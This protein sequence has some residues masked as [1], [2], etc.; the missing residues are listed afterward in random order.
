MWQTQGLRAKYGPC[1][2]ANHNYVLNEQ[3]LVIVLC[4][5]FSVFQV[6][7]VKLGL[8]WPITRSTRVQCEADRTLHKHKMMNNQLLT[9]RFCCDEM[10]QEEVN[11]SQ[12]RDSENTDHDP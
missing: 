12:N 5:F 11:H 6:Q 9:D 4:I 1:L 2:T 7:T 3:L 10:K 8:F